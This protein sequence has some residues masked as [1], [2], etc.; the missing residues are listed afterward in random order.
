[1]PTTIELTD[2]QELAELKACTKETGDSAAVRS[3]MT[4]YLRLA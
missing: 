3:A 4:E 2:E 1:M